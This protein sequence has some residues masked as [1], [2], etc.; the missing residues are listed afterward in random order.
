MFSRLSEPSAVALNQESVSGTL[1]PD[2]RVI[3]QGI[4]CT[5]Q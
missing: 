4:W 5:Q 1:H 2:L 3:C